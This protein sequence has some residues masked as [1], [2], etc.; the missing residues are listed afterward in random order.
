MSGNTLYVLSQCIAALAFIAGL[1]GF[2][3][4]EHKNVLIFFAICS[5]LSAS[6]FA[7]LFAWTASLV[8]FI[9]GIRHI[10]AIYFRNYLA[11]VLFLGVVVISTILTY[12]EPVNLL[13]AFSAGMG[14]IGSFSKNTGR[15]RLIWMVSSVSYII[16]NYLVHSPVATGMEI[17]FLFSNILAYRRYFRVPVQKSI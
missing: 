16:H 15:A 4:R 3:S 2:Q 7:L 8:V 13:A 17:F 1:A 14:T 9:S 12:Q 6:H 5:F 10:V 11:L